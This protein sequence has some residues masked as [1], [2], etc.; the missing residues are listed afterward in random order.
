[1]KTG[2]HI[3]VNFQN[4][5]VWETFKRGT[6]LTVP[7]SEVREYVLSN[8]A[9]F[10]MFEHTKYPIDHTLLYVHVLNMPS[11]E[12]RSTVLGVGMPGFNFL[13]ELLL[14]SL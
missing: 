5:Q 6:D 9:S 4:V 1:M 11:R 12:V 2:N 3:L 10:K 7:I 13:L 14:I 8:G